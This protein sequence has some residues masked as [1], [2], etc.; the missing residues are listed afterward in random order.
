MSTIAVKDLKKLQATLN[1][2]GLDYQLELEYGM[3]S[4]FCI[5]S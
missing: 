4:R 3:R 1:Q 5:E 2:A